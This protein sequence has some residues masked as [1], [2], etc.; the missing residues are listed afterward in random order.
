MAE[1]LIHHQTPDI[2]IAR[3]VRDETFFAGT[4][5][6]SSCEELVDIKTY[7]RAVRRKVSSSC[8][9]LTANGFY[10]FIIRLA[11]ILRWLPKYIWKEDLLPDITGGVTVGIMHVPLGNVLIIQKRHGRHYT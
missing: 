5:C 3:K 8:T 6:R 9:C 4:H 11:P 1:I 2:I 10:S 7:L